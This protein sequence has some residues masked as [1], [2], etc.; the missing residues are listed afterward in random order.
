M[1]PP[2]RVLA[3][4]SSQT[5]GTYVDD[6]KS[7]ELSGSVLGMSKCIFPLE[8]SGGWTCL[9]WE[10]DVLTNILVS[11]PVNDISYITQVLITINKLTACAAELKIS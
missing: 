5:Y 11:M 3:Y 10:I 7:R 9:Y 4:L 8:I 2:G 1:L 6:S